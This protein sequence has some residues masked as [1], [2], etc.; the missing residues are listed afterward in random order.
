MN[1]NQILSERGKIHG[2][3]T[4]NSAIAQRLKAV[5]HS[6]K[7]WNELEPYQA[8]AIEMIL[9]KLGRILSGDPHYLDHWADIVG[10]SQ[11]V[12]DRLEV[13]QNTNTDEQSSTSEQPSCSLF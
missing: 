12:C 9:H 5:V 7:N 6:S 10:Y 8:E 11:L 3:F 2:D 13:K 1:V 4:D